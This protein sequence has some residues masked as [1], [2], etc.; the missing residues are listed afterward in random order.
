MRL[1]L[2]YPLGLLLTTYGAVLAVHGAIVGTPVLG[3]N[4]NLDWG[5]VLIAAGAAALYLAM[6]RKDSA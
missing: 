6:R 3:I 2:R 5:L 4:V 1:D